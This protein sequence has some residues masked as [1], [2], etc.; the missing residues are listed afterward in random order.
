MRLM[1]HEQWGVCFELAKVH[2]RVRGTQGEL[3]IL[4]AV[5][6]IILFTLIMVLQETQQTHAGVFMFVLP[7]MLYQEGQTDELVQFRAA[8]QEDQAQYG[9]C[10]GSHGIKIMNSPLRDVKVMRRSSISLVF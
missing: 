10:S 9:E 3:C 7:V 8:G 2:D 1:D 6:F 4:V 5:L